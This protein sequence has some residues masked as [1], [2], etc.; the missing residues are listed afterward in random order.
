[1]NV[2]VLDRHQVCSS[3][4]V[5]EEWIKTLLLPE[6]QSSYSP[7]DFR[8]TALGFFQL[9]DSLCQLSEQHL[10]NEL[11]D[12]M[13][14]NLI[15]TNVLS[16][17]QLNEQ[18]QWLINQFQR[19]SPSSFL[20]TLQSIRAMISDNLLIPIFET[21]WQW[22][23]PNI[24]HSKYWG[25]KLNTKPIIYNGSCNCGL[26]S[27]CF[28]ESSTMPGFMVGCYP[29]ESLLKSNLQ[30]LYNASCF[31]Q[32][33]NVNQSISALHDSKTSRYEKDTTVELILNELM[34][35]QWFNSVI[36]ENYYNKCAPSLCS[37]SYTHRRS[38]LEVLAFL[39]GLQSGLLIIMNVV[40]R[41]VVAVWHKM[42][43]RGPHHNVQIHP[44]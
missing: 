19:N 34:V 16:P 28:Q 31:S 33:S 40:A 22:M 8:K 14:R 2:T 3:A 4:F 29:L 18:I 25:I 11:F 7:M 42:L 37:Y 9:L 21:N 35:D 26:S 36:Y 1:M 6:P 43:I 15:N 13:S 38:A 41:M 44:M 5:R 39:L 30:C 20:T 32:L 10:A 24:N 17:V 23:D 12:F 27:Q